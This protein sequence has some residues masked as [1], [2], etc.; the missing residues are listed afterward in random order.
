MIVPHEGAIDKL[1]RGFDFRLLNIKN[2][3]YMGA[4]YQM[5]RRRDSKLTASV[6]VV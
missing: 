1:Y 2:T 6:Q 5:R 3:P 4:L